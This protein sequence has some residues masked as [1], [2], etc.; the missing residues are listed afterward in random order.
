MGE[1]CSTNWEKR[2]AYTILVRKPEGRPRR[3]WVDNIVACRPVAR[4]RPQNKQLC[5]SSC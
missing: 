2:K 3:R 1:A 5:N 4:Q